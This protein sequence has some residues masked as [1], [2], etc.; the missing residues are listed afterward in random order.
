MQKYEFRKNARHFFR[1]PLRCI[2]NRCNFAARL[3]ARQPVN[4]TTCTAA[5]MLYG[6]HDVYGCHNVTA[7]LTAERKGMYG[8]DSKTNCHVSMPSLA[9][10]LVNLDC[11]KVIGEN[12]YA[13]A[14]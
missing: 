10:T 5:T 9:V 12:N 3:K 6:R 7:L 14:A 13:L 1:K 2:E 8:F 4:W 11:K